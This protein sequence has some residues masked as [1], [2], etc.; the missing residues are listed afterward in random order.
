MTNNWQPA[1]TT[2][3]QGAAACEAA[4]SVNSIETPTE[5]LIPAVQAARLF[6]RTTRTLRNWEARGLLSGVRIGRSLYFKL[7]EM[8]QLIAGGA[9]L[10]TNSGEDSAA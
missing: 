1:E 7:S 9:Y 10:H 2:D 8:E 4:P 5:K 3:E 6:H